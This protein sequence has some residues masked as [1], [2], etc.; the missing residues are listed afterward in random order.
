ML[1]STGSLLGAACLLAV[2]APGEALGLTLGWE[3][4]P[5]CPPSEVVEAEIQRLTSSHDTAALVASALVS[6][7]AD[8]RFRVVI[9]ISGSA[10]GHRELF[11]DTCAQLAKATALIIALAANPDAAID[12]A[13]E[14]IDPVELEE[15][16]ASQSELGPRGVELTRTPTPAPPQAAP[17]TRR[18][19]PRGGPRP[20]HPLTPPYRV[21]LF[22]HVGL[23][24]GSLPSASA[25]ARLGGRLRLQN[26]TQQL[27][28][29]TTQNV[30]HDAQDGIGAEFSLTGAEL[31]F[32]VSALRENPRLDACGGGRLDVLE[33]DGHGG[34]RAYD[35]HV[36]LPELVVGPLL[37]L[38]LADPWR[39]ELL[40]ELGWL[41]RRPRF[42]VA[43]TDEVLFQPARITFTIGMGLGYAL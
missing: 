6:R 39:L 26:L 34:A 23:A 14:T 8:A 17:T 4:P 43:N 19:P 27:S 10:T 2:I 5:I 32:C 12:L 21:E 31:L 25:L 24:Q 22:G 18:G 36:W 3:A 33:A 1:P 35:R 37:G 11:A 9:D 30:N 38:E 16:P 20:H 41:S 42:V 28:L 29:K 15:S 7:T 40:P 13:I